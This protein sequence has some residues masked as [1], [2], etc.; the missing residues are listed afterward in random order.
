MKKTI[1]GAITALV[2]LI[3][4]AFIVY[5]SN[6]D[7]Q[8]ITAGPQVMKEDKISSFSTYY[9]NEVFLI[10]SVQLDRKKEGFILSFHIKMKQTNSKYQCIIDKNAKIALQTDKGKYEKSLKTWPDI[11]H[12]EVTSSIFFDNATGKLK[13]FTI[14]GVQI[15]DAS[16]NIPMGYQSSYVPI[17][18]ELQTDCTSCKQNKQ[19][20]NKR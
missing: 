19:N 16:G 20:G 8:N 11:K 10:N 2:L 15:T 13:A 18:L 14:Q 7:Q 3:I 1:Y 4:G 9:E 6:F 12:P 5:P 17:H